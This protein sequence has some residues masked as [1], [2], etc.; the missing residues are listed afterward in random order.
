MS[1]EVPEDLKGLKSAIESITTKVAEGK[2]QSN[3]YNISIK[4]NLINIVNLIKKLKNNNFL[5]EL[6]K[7]QK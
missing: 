5:T 6:P 1:S 3:E 4:N 7:V 2:Q